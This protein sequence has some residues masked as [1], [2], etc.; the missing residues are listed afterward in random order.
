MKKGNTKN[1]G[2][3][4][5]LA[6]APALLAAGLAACG[7]AGDPPP[8]WGEEDH[9]DL[10]IAST[11]SEGGAVALDWDFEEPVE[12]TFVQCFGDSS[13]DCSAGIRLY[14]SEEPGFV[15]LTEDHADEGFFALPDG[16]EVTLELVSKDVEA[17][18][19]LETGT[20]DQPGDTVVLGSTPD[21]HAHGSWQLAI[22][23]SETPQDEYTI[24]LRVLASGSFSA[25]T[26]YVVKI[27]AEDP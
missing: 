1:L 19:A 21:L 11:E 27:H 6:L 24:T 3:A 2:P 16:V 18:L 12:T 20:L 15:Q 13:D 9:G 8:G 14:S 10:A 5:T 22:P 25:S 7:G 26:D 23:G 4:W 17:S